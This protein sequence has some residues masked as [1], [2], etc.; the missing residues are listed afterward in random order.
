MKNYLVNK[1]SGF[2]LTAIAAVFSFAGIFIYNTV[3]YRFTPVYFLLTAAVVLKV[4]VAVISGFA[5]NKAVFNL[6]PI[7]N[8]VLMASAAVWS[9]FLMV[10]QIGYVVASLDP[11][12]TITTFITFVIVAVAAMLLNIAASFTSLEK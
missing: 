1:A 11:V 3:M 7:A 10:N 4:L 2:Y 9:V 5:G 8:A 12:S 6:L